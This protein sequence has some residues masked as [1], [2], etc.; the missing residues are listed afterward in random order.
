MNN[1][2]T[3]NNELYFYYLLIGTGIIIS[4]SLYYF[5]RSNNTD[6]L[7]KNIEPLTN[8]E[9]EEILAENSMTISNENI[10]IIDNDYFIDTESDYQTDSQSSIDSQSTIDIDVNDLDLFFMPD[11][12]LNVVSLYELKLFEISSIFRQEILDNGIT[13]EELIDM[14]SIFPVE[15]LCTN[16]INEAILLIINNLHNMNM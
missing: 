2:L 5:I 9:I 16:T 8:E 11:V 6:N 1:Y 15:D 4:C 12:D 14:I 7:I 13:E 10:D 3:Y